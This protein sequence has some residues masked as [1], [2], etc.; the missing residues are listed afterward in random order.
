MNPVTSGPVSKASVSGSAHGTTAIK[1]IVYGI[2]VVI[3]NYILHVFSVNPAVL[4]G[5]TAIVAFIVKEIELYFPAV[6]SIGL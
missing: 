5:A 1:S 6:S 4:G 3:V 2:L